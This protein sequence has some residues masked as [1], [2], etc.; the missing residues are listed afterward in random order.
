MNTATLTAISKLLEKQ[1]KKARKKLKPGEHAIDTTV[2]LH[3][4]GTLNVDPDTEYAPTVQIPWKTAFALFLKYAGITRETA[5]EHLVAAMQH[6][7]NTDQDAAELLQSLADLE[8]AEALVQEGLD[9]LPKQPR[10]GSV[11][12]KKLTLTEIQQGR[13][14]A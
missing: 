1:A 8:E 10:A 2:V 7:L 9:E 5:M 12:T 3:V 6:A 4:Q 13:R 11:R 14:A